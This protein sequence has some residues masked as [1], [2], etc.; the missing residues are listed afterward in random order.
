MRKLLLGLT[1]LVTCFQ[2]YSQ[3]VQKG[4]TAANGQFI[5]FYEY[6][7]T[8]YS[9]TSTKKYP[10]IIFLH[11]IGERGNGTTDLIK[12][13][14]HAI[15][16]IIAAGGTMTYK[17]P[18]TGE[19]ETFLVL[20]PQ[21]SWS[22]GYWD[23]MYIDE[24][25]KY[26]KQN[27]N[28][29][30][31]RIYLTG[32]SAGGGGT[33]RYPNASLANASQFAAIAPVCPT[34]DFNL[35]T[36]GNTIVAA[37]TAVWSF[38]AADDY[39]CGYYCTFGPVDA[40]NTMNPATPA[41]K[42]I[43]PSGGHYIWE[44]V[45][46]SPAVFEWFLG[47]SRGGTPMPGN[48]APVARAGTDI[49]ITLPVN[50]V[51]LNNS[52]SSDA[53]GSITAFK[54][55]QV[56]GPSVSFIA[57]A[58]AASTQVS[59]LVAGTYTF[60]LTVTDNAGATAYDDVVVVVNA[61]T[62]ALPPVANAGK[63]Q[64]IPVGQATALNG[65]ASSSP[66]GIRSFAWVK[67]SGPAVNMVSPNSAETWIN[68]TLAGTYTFRL[69]VTDNNGNSAF[70]DVIV[71]V[72][73]GTTTTPP[74]TSA[75]VANAGK[76]QSLPV[77]QATALNGSGSTSSVGIKSYLWTKVSGP[78][79][80]MVSPNTSE[81]WINGTVSGTYVF[82]LTITDNNGATAF[83]EVTITVGSGTTTTPTPP[84][85]SAPVANAG[86]DLTLPVG[87]ATAL[88]GSGSTAAAGIKS[89]AWVKASGPSVNMV[90]PNSVENWINGTLAGTYVFKLT[91]T[92]N[93]GVIA[94]D[95]VVITVGSGISTTTTTTT[96][97]I[98]GPV[99]N[100]GKDETLPTGQATVLRGELSTATAGIRSYTWTK[101]SGPTAFNIISPT[102]SSSWLNSL[103]AGTYVFRLTVTDN[104]GATATD[105]VVITVTAPLSSTTTGSRQLAVADEPIISALT[106]PS[107]LSLQ[108]PARNSLNVNWNAD[109]KGSAK[110]NIMDVNGKLLKTLNVKK[111]QQQ[112]RNNIELSGLKQGL[113][114]LQIQTED[115]K[116][117]T[118]KFVKK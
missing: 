94:S 58:G 98:T 32:L 65:T 114:I 27:L 82:R 67:T 42:T 2:T 72:G 19:M 15:P 28:V 18:V 45:Y 37:K 105:D 34:C 89:Y 111:Q 62:S 66:A 68:N 16:R 112:F 13:T 49:T 59:A 107:S 40:I 83:D 78:S 81:N 116:T 75:T 55:T 87:Q 60:R 91:I 118:R 9:S 108:N 96:S 5:G 6:K 88:S 39:V 110:M 25:L 63:D 44:I 93:N 17:N 106:S 100:A 57:S 14:W 69:T 74:A 7:P 80:N 4:L 8:T 10:L 35:S 92:D 38:H 104:N 103:V 48:Q 1:L 90:S 33:W 29:D 43:Y 24:M 36:I 71:T 51:T 52:G 86:K 41:K 3:Q 70:D 20:S 61:N 84:S 102:A 12:V 115:G 23:F 21:L 26:A 31:N 76:D 85:T 54:W 79:V 95:E 56:S 113:H 64:S 73:S 97:T 22:Y 50:A 11:G 109:Y 99:A 47:N 30:E 101:F 77:G 53:D 46:T 117:L